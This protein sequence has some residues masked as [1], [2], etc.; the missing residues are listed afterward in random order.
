MVTTLFKRS[1]ILSQK[2]TKSR[3]ILENGQR[4]Y[5]HC[6]Y[7]N[8]GGA[9]ANSVAIQ[10][11]PKGEW[12]LIWSG[13]MERIADPCGSLSTDPWWPVPFVDTNQYQMMEWWHTW[14]L[15]M[16][17]AWTQLSKVKEQLVRVFASPLTVTVTVMRIWKR[18]IIPKVPHPFP[19]HRIAVMASDNLWSALILR[20]AS[21]KVLGEAK[22]VHLSS[23]ETNIHKFLIYVEEKASRWEQNV[24]TLPICPNQ[25]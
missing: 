9:P 13:I 10:R 18:R 19:F 4:H 11:L 23:S 7:L 1:Q 14:S 5:V 20:I 21:K 8:L 12:L 25:N 24:W 22:Y 6:S 2:R 16:D 3:R 17:P 15:S